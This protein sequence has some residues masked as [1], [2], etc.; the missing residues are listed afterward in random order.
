MMKDSYE[1][2]IIWANGEKN[3]YEYA[4]RELAEYSAKNFLMAFGE[5]VA[6]YCVRRAL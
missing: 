6:W 5:Q 3:V 2:V 4:C 1:L